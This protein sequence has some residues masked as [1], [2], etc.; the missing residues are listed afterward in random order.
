M[1]TLCLVTLPNSTEERIEVD[2]RENARECLEKVCRDLGT[3]ETDYFGL[4]YVS[5]RGQHLWLNLRNPIGQQMQGPGPHRLRLRVKFYVQ[6]HFLQQESTREQVY[7]NVRQD[8][9]EGRLHVQD[10]HLAAVIGALIAQA[11][12]GDA[13]NL[14]SDLTPSQYPSF[15]PQMDSSIL[16]M[17]QAEHLKLAGL[18]PQTA[19]YNLIRDVVALVSYGV[20]HYEVKDASNGQELY[21]GVGP[22]GLALYEQGT[23]TCVKQIEYSAMHQATQHGKSLQLQILEE[24]GSMTTDYHYSMCDK[25]Y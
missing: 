3:L 6:P 9:L 19:K 25:T 24:N 13:D 18:A 20:E 16:E 8:L 22:E 7:L 10:P 21:M 2:P 5:T 11:E 15:L 17:L 4:Q 1:S 23:W 14:S 12:L